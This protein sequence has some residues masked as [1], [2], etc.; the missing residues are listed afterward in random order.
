MINSNTQSY[1]NKE[2]DYIN[3]KTDNVPSTLI[4]ISGC[5]EQEIGI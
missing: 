5:I 3:F 2:I 1:L 4:V